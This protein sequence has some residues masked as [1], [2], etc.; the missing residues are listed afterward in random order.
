MWRWSWYGKDT[1]DDYNSIS[2]SKFHRWKYLNKG[3]FVSWTITRS[4]WGEVFSRMWVGIDRDNK[5]ALFDFTGTNWVTGEKKKYNFTI[6]IIST[7]CN[8]GWDRYW[9]VCPSCRKK[10]GKLYLKNFM[11]HCRKCLNLCYSDQNQGT[12]WR[13]LT[14]IYPRYHDAEELY[15]TI[16]YKFRN[17]N[18]TRKYRR[19]CKM[20]RRGR[21]VEALEAYLWYETKKLNRI[22]KIYG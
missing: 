22:M 6:D 1:T 10:K 19:Y 3:E 4:R 13:L 20:M 14:R 7:P 2:I 18:M 12:M 15:K 9:F 5:R 17:G 8:Y 16:K 11:F 21:D